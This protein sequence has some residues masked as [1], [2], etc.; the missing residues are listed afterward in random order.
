MWVYLF[1]RL[2]DALI[3]FDGIPPFKNVDLFPGSWTGDLSI[4]RNMSET[5]FAS[6]WVFGFI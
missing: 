3:Y 4:S 6:K 2:R 5:Y 1:I